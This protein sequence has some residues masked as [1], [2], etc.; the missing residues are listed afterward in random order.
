M[1]SIGLETNSS[2]RTPTIFLQEENPVVRGG[3][4]SDNDPIFL[5]QQQ[6]GYV[7]SIASQQNVLRGGIHR[8][9]QLHTIGTPRPSMFETPSRPA[10][11]SRSGYL[12]VPPRE[13]S[14]GD[15]APPSAHHTDES[16]PSNYPNPAL[17]CGRGKPRRVR[18]GGGG[19]SY[20]SSSPVHFTTSCPSHS[21]VVS[22]SPSL[23]SSGTV[24]AGRVERRS[25]TI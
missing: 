5:V 8:P 18:R 24:T 7:R 22:Y 2:R 21:P 1:G 13:R 23:P 25:T 16:S 6:D 12:R 15:V 11:V 17:R 20:D 19:H 14:T 9:L 10:V 4:E 3:R